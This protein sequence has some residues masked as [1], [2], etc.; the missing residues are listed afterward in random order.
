MYSW[1]FG[2]LFG[3]STISYITLIYHEIIRHRSTLKL[4]DIHLHEGAMLYS[5]DKNLPHLLSVFYGMQLNQ[6]TYRKFYKYAKRYIRGNFCILYDCV[7][8][9]ISNTRLYFR[10]LG[11]NEMGFAALD[12]DNKAFSEVVVKADNCCSESFVKWFDFIIKS[13]IKEEKTELQADER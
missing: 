4:F 1:I 10:K 12:S 5:Q 8:K 11:W 2:I 9:E 7:D 6:V 3:V 13:S